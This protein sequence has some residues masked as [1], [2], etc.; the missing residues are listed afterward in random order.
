MLTDFSRPTRKLLIGEDVV[1]DTAFWANAAYSVGGKYYIIVDEATLLDYTTGTSLTISDAGPGAQKELD[2]MVALADAA[3]AAGTAF[4][5]STLSELANATGMNVES[6]E[7]TV[8]RYNELV[9]NGAD[10]DYAKASESMV[11]TVESG[12]YY[13]FDCRAVYLGTI[14]GVK[15]DEK[16]QVIDVDYNPILGQIGRAHV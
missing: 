16:L 15:V 9:N 8:A 11:Y 12:N 3:V 1:Y 4:K 13:A 14:G 2:D 5:G 6:L 7:A 10:T